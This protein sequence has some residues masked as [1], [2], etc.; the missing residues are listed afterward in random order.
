MAM[1][2]RDDE[3]EQLFVTHANLRRSG[4]HPF[5]EALEKIL[6]AQGFDR[7]VEEL[8]E[9]FYKLGGRPSIPPGVY[10]RCLLVGLFE[11]IDSERGIAWRVADSMSLRGF[12]GLPLDKNPPDHSTLSRTRRLIDLE[13][14]QQVFA[15]A[16]ALLAKAGLVKGKTVGFDAT[17]LEANAAM[18]SIVRRD[19]GQGYED[20]LTE[21]AQASGI[22]TPTREDLAKLDRKRPK[23]GSNADWVH[24]LEPEA[25]ITKM[26]DGSTH[27]AHKQEHGVDMDT[28][29][30]LGV[31]LHG[32][33]K[34]DTKTV[35]ETIVA[36][37][38][39]LTAVHEQVDE[40]T[41]K[42]VSKRIREAVLDKGYHSNEVL[43]ALEDSE[44]RAYISE[45]DRGRR[46]WKD[47]HVE[48]DAVYRNRRRMR[49][50]RGKHLMRKRGE[51]IE[52]P[53][54][55]MHE[56]GRMR[57][58]HLRHHD[59]ILKR[60]LI[61]AA[62]ANLCLLM[63]TLVGVGTPRSLQGRRGLASLL[64]QALFD[65]LAALVAW[66]ARRRRYL[67]TTGASSASEWS[68]WP[69][70]SAGA[71]GSPSGVRLAFTTGC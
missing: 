4:G 50:R 58:T 11:G 69:E 20:F 59:N 54:A 67:A 55:H 51:L 18:R 10:F 8:C 35:D 24:P 39:N 56:T 7:Y 65:A 52:R 61:H 60:L 15:W 46:C 38:D 68:F 33:A 47:K 12:L 21:L 48:R 43:V 2:H 41:A 44:I 42:K 45:P 28:G 57:R 36:V 1:G 53:F 27:L 64:L 63:R 71:L 62:G 26:K 5:Y 13:T 66:W 70:R 31:T 16:L 14:H 6:K 17:T 37:E 49:G 34:H 32:G 29:A 30:I 23:K 3:Q 40:E 22:E 19:D 25:Q 9:R